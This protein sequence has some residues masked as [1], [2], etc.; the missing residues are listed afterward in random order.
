M[1]KRAAL[2][3]LAAALATAALFGASALAAPQTTHYGSGCAPNESNP[4]ERMGIERLGAANGGGLPVSGVITEWQMSFGELIPFKTKTQ[5]IKVVREAGESYEVV[6]ESAAEPMASAAEGVATR[7]PIQKGDLLG[8][9]SQGEN[10]VLFDCKEQG[11]D[12]H[13]EFSTGDPAIGSSVHRG[14]G[15]TIEHALPVEVTIE[16]D[17]DGDGYG[18]LTQD[19][20]PADPAAH[21]AP[22]PPPAVAPSPP[23]AAAAAPHP[24]ALAVAHKGSATV[25]VTSDLAGSVAVSGRVALGGGASATIRGAPEPVVAGGTASFTLK[26]PK[27]LKRRL[28]SLP[29]KRKLKLKVTATATSAAGAA[30]SSTATVA[31]H[32]QG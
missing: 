7:V 5:R 24:L 12:E 15:G 14:S 8:L 10:G 2:S 29:P 9:S 4:G 16:P 23:P 26:F 6:G 21:L 25:K 11:D 30:G 22:C 1:R 18:D 32:G 27:A 20:C 13:V 19:A 17:A 3:V 31:L 28:A